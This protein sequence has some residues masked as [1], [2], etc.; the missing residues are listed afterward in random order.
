MLTTCYRLLLPGGNEEPGYQITNDDQP[1]RHNRY[2]SES[3]AECPSLVIRVDNRKNEE[4]EMRQ[5]LAILDEPEYVSD[6]NVEL[7]EMVLK[8]IQNAL[9]GYPSS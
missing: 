3:N 7:S 6:G 9:F 1:D 2:D 8:E 4:S 5:I